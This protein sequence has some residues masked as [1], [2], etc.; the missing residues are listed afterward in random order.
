MPAKGQTV[1]PGAATPHG[2][3]TRST[4][5]TGKERASRAPISS[6]G[7][8]TPPA[9]TTVQHTQSTES[10]STR[11][12]VT[13]SKQTVTRNSAE[14]AARPSGTAGTAAPGT[15]RQ[16]TAMPQ[17]GR[18]VPPVTGPQPP[19]QARS[20]PVQ[21]ETRQT[22]VSAKAPVG[23]TSPVVRPGTAGTASE[24][25]RGQ[26]ERTTARKTSE[27]TKSG[28]KQPQAPGIKRQSTPPAATGKKPGP[29]TPDR[30]RGSGHG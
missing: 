8:A 19:K 14:R 29:K 15:V 20:S 24:T 10:R 26:I 17:A 7:A 25:R 30:S 16:P 2:V 13:E 1:Q 23:G 21:Q 27:D 18:V 12:S 3:S 22:S 6:G 28:A 11:R 5:I 4:K 9:T